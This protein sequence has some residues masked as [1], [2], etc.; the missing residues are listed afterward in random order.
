MKQAAA[1][2]LQRPAALAMPAALAARAED[3]APVPEAKSGMGAE[4]NA[5]ENATAT[6]SADTSADDGADSEQGLR[7]SA[8]LETWFYGNW[9]QR[10]SGSLLNPDNRIARPPGGQALLYVE[11]NFVPRLT[12]FLALT[13]TFGG[14]ATEYGALVCTLL[15]VGVKFFA[16]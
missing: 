5:A 13:R 10:A 14:A 3:A 8:S 15:T 11:K 2:A 1:Q 7:Y 4:E 12:G 16:F 6:A 9:T